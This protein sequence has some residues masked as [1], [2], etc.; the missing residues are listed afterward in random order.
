MSLLV[1]R[2]VAAAALS[3]A[4]IVLTGCGGTPVPT[5][6]FVYTTLDD[7]AEAKRLTPEQC[8]AAIDKALVEHDTKATKY[9]TLQDCEKK[10][11]AERCE[12]FAERHYRPRL[13]GYLFTVNASVVAAPLYP[14]LKSATVMRDAA[15]AVLDWQRTEGVT[16]SQEAI[17]RARGFA[18]VKPR[19]RG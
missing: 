2:A 9:I 1:K 7:C 19:G 10:E 3:L 8:G 4:A 5:E 15:G 13:V 16:F 18:A 6:K 11:G 12:K 14:G 17:V